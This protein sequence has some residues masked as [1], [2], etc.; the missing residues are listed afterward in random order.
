MKSP[1]KKET[2][3]LGVGRHALPS[4][5]V[6]RVV[7]NLFGNPKNIIFDT[8]NTS[9]S[10]HSSHW[11]TLI[12]TKTIQQSTWPCS[13][14]KSHLKKTAHNKTCLPIKKQSRPKCFPHKKHRTT[15]TPGTGTGTSWLAL[16]AYDRC[17]ATDHLPSRTQAAGPWPSR[18]TSSGTWRKFRVKQTTAKSRWQD[19]VE[20][21]SAAANPG[22][23]FRM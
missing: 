21:N 8:Q 10:V 17:M 15:I 11:S 4:N 1:G 2:K 6:G 3:K 23:R 16:P 20:E 9:I 13:N 19:L 12:L 7:K 18:C 5:G 22:V 14:P